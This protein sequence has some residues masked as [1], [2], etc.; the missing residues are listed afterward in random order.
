[1]QAV[2][3]AVDFAVP[4]K[5]IT[6]DELSATLDT[7]D[8]WIRSHTGIGSR[9]VA[10]P[11]I[12]TSDLAFEACQ[13][14]LKQAGVPASEVDLIL[15]ATVTG[16]YIGFPSVS[17][18]VQDKLGASSAA[19]MDIL[20][21][22]HGLH[23]RPGDCPQL[24]RCRG[25]QRRC[26]WSG[27]RSSAGSPTGRIAIRACSLAMAQ[28]PPWLPLRTADGNRGIISSILRADGSGALQLIRPAGGYPVAV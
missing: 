19:A 17:C 22:L 7:S 2:I 1:M 27:R 12:F 20:A 24:R 11:S 23:L 15:V 9:H 13:K 16:D 5:R 26:W 4:E 21:R 14:V 3:Q 6:N 28:A 10:G 8:E 18:I 25:A